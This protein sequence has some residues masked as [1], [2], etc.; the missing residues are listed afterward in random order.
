MFIKYRVFKDN[1]TEQQQSFEEVIKKQKEQ[2][3]FC[4]IISGE[5]PTEKVYEDD[6]VIGIMDINPTVDGH[7]LFMPK[8]HYPIMPLIPREVFEKMFSISRYICRAIEEAFSCERTT[9]FIA[10]GGVAGQQSTHFM[11]HILP[12]NSGDVLKNLDCVGDINESTDEIKSVLKTNVFAGMQSLGE[13]HKSVARFLPTS[14]AEPHTEDVQKQEEGKGNSRPSEEQKKR[15]SQL[16]NENE[17]FRK[18]LL[19]DPDKL[20]ELIQ[21]NNEWSSLFHGIDI[22]ALVSKLREMN[23]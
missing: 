6:K 21:S 17:E 4:K 11:M 3:I 15:I 5:I 19:D 10:N 1:M 14:S 18:L 16:F 13:Q 7:V 12:R 8:E 22:D 9:V 2:C 23:Q 20:K